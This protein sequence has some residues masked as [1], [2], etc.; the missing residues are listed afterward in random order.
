MQE[1]Q[2]DDQTPETVKKNE[3]LNFFDTVENIFTKFNAEPVTREKIVKATEDLGRILD[4]QQSRDLAD[5]EYFIAITENVYKAY[6]EFFIKLPHE[7]DTNTGTTT[8]SSDEILDTIIRIQD[9]AI[10]RLD[11]SQHPEKFGFYV[12]L[13][14]QKRNG[15]YFQH[16]N[17]YYHFGIPVISF[18]LPTDRKLL[19]QVVA[20]KERILTEEEIQTVYEAEKNTYKIHLS[21]P[22]ERRIEVLQAILNAKRA[23]AQIST[24][25]RTE[26]EAS[27]IPENTVTDSE[28]KE[29]GAKCTSVHRFK[30][31]EF[32]DNGTNSENDSGALPDFV[33]YPPIIEGQD[34]QEALVEMAHELSS[35]L[36]NLNL[37][38]ES[39]TPRFSTPIEINGVAVPGM[40]FVQGNGDFKTH[41]LEKHGPEKLSQYYDE[42]KNWALRKG[43]TINF[44]TKVDNKEMEEISEHTPSQA[45]D[46]E[47]KQPQRN[48]VLHLLK[49]VFRR[50]RQ[51]KTENS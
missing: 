13:M 22:P 9:K 11:F 25:I 35:L 18:G 46:A 27:G 5:L 21:V 4:S 41:I 49:N 19:Q 23:D 28:L 45:R 17:G 24:R 51:A 40:T 47:K 3:E 38:S 44:E 26:K 2:V 43:V 48:R 50:N 15:S 34:P 39:K 16:T 31:L 10:N 37:E 42:S 30:M 36:A 1:N 7:E 32:S 20:D 6:E 29:R 33:F 14:A 12:K 8:Q